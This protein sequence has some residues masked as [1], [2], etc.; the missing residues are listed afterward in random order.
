M[1]TGENQTCHVLLEAEE[2]VQTL[3]E[4]AG[5]HLFR[6]KRGRDHGPAVSPMRTVSRCSPKYVSENIH[7]SPYPIA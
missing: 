7:G 5:Q 2:A 4:A 6:V 3:W 1:V